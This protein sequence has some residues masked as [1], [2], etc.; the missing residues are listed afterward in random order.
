MERDAV[1]VHCAADGLRRP[2]RVPI[3]GEDA[4]RL[5]PI[6]AGFPC[7]G[8][9]LAGYVE[10]TRDDDAEKNRVCPSSPY[11][12]TLADWAEMTVLGARS[13]MAFGAEPDIAQW[14][15]GVALNPARTPPGYGPSADLDDV[16]AR[17][18]GS[19]Q[20]GI[21]ALALLLSTR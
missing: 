18:S 12:S 9:A 10:A 17:L 8:A 21:A 15:R 5:Q 14:A 20:A 7:F 13:A 11:S 16:K 4:I 6:R 1:V 2:P 19:L 3:W